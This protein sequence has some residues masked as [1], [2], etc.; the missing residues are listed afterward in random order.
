[1]LEKIKLIRRRAFN[2]PLHRNGLLA[3]TIFSLTN[4]Q[5]MHNIL[6]SLIL[7]SLTYRDNVRITGANSQTLHN[8]AALN[9]CTLYPRD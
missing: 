4:T 7:R 8:L 2:T 9:A 5:G 6:H 1:M 3:V